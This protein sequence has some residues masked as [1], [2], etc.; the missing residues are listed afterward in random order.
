[1]CSWAGTI[2]VFI[3]SPLTFLDIWLSWC[4]RPSGW[5]AILTSSYLVIEFPVQGVIQNTSCVRGYLRRKMGNCSPWIP[6]WSIFYLRVIRVGTARTCPLLPLLF[7]PIHLDLH[8]HWTTMLQFLAVLFFS[9]LLIPFR[10]TAQAS[11]SANVTAAAID[12]LDANRMYYLYQPPGMLIYFLDRG[13]DILHFLDIVDAFGHISV[14]NPDNESQFIM[15]PSFSTFLHFRF[16]I[17]G[18]SFAVAPALTTSQSLVTYTFLDSLC[19]RFVLS[20]LPQIW[21]W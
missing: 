10:V 1:M 18:R 14:R 2:L 7:K 17:L 8:S 9:C 13:P 15:Y 20:I 5:I 3:S 4:G 16:L 6:V 12:L 11:P 19:F 21:H